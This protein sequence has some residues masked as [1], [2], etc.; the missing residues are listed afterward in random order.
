MLFLGYTIAITFFT[1]KGLYP[2]SLCSEFLF[3][4]A[5][6]IVLLSFYTEVRRRPKESLILHDEN[7]PEMQGLNA[8]NYD[9]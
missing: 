2:L 4:C 5:F 7:T 9:Y 3:Y 8:E 1:N 6:V